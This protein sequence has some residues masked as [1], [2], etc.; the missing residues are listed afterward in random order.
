MIDLRDTKT[1]LRLPSLLPDQTKAS[2]SQNL[3]DPELK[4]EQ[5]LMFA[6]G[7]CCAIKIKKYSKMKVK[8]EDDNHN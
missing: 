8:V 4:P 3:F 5:V 6:L 1:Q 2:D 7:S